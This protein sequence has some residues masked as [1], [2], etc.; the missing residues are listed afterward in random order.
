[1]LP[2]GQTATGGH[3]QHPDTNGND[4]NQRQRKA[5]GD[6]WT[7]PERI[8]ANLLKHFNLMVVHR[9]ADSIVFNVFV[10]APSSASQ[11]YRVLRPTSRTASAALVLN[12]SA[13]CLAR[14]SL[15]LPDFED[16]TPLKWVFHQSPSSRPAVVEIRRVS[17]TQ[18]SLHPHK[19]NG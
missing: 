3:D 19:L 1:M 13:I 17:L 2:C 5:S 18:T 12:S 14:A 10:Q 9:T 11:R 6:E 4:A 8:M 16:T 15:L 7:C